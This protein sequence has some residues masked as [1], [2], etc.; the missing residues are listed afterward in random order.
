MQSGSF[1]RTDDRSSPSPGIPVVHAFCRTCRS[2]VVPVVLPLSLFLLCCP[3][4]GGRRRGDAGGGGRGGG[5]GR[6]TA[7]TTRPRWS[8]SCLFTSSWWRAVSIASLSFSSGSSW[9]F[10]DTSLS[11]RP[12]TNLSLIASSTSGNLQ[13]AASSYRARTYCSTVS[14]SACCRKW[15]FARSWITFTLGTKWV[16]NFPSTV[17]TSCLGSGCPSAGVGNSKLEK[18][19]SASLPIAY[20]KLA[21]CTSP[22]SLF[23][24]VAMRNRRNLSRFWPRGWPSKVERLGGVEFR[25]VAK[26]VT[27]LC[28][29]SVS[30]RSPG[31]P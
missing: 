5:A 7:S 20:T 9:S 15:N 25:H 26:T 18:I 4:V 23:S 16:L 2:F 21:T 29:S 27:Y 13:F 19:F 6:R 30:V 12:S 8:E 17:S 1:F 28:E 11:R 22:V 3:G 10:F 24:L 31:L 14:P